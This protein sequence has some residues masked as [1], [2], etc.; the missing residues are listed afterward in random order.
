MKQIYDEHDKLRN[1][2]ILYD[3]AAT[4]VTAVSAFRETIIDINKPFKVYIDP[5]CVFERTLVDVNPNVHRVYDYSIADVIIIPKT[6][7]TKTTKNRYIRCELIQDK[8]KFY[9]YNSNQ[10]SETAAVR[11]FYSI[12]TTMS[13]YIYDRFPKLKTYTDK[14]LSEEFLYTILQTN[15]TPDFDTIVTYL[16]SDDTAVFELGATLLSGVPIDKYRYEICKLLD[17]KI[18]HRALKSLCE[19]STFNS[20]I[21]PQLIDGWYSSYT[22][23][24]K[25]NIDKFTDKQQQE[26]FNTVA[27]N[28]IIDKIIKHP[29]YHLL[30]KTAV[31]LNIGWYINGVQKNQVTVKLST[32]NNETYSKYTNPNSLP[33]S[34]CTVSDCCVKFYSQLTGDSLKEINEYLGEHFTDMAMKY[35]FF[36]NTVKI[37]LC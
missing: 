24:S 8:I 7:I 9:P 29:T 13:K 21:I 3:E 14:L 2:L 23:F 15:A 34:M 26:W 19:N 10:G 37:K 32:F 35:P 27:S 11:C 5:T 30:M 16:N 17:F 25:A 28:F 12:S 31:I 20:L 18:L 4:Y 6:C 36:T 22:Y 1:D 33:L